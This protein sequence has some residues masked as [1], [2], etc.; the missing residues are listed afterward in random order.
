MTDAFVMQHPLLSQVNTKKGKRKA[1]T[2]A[3][4]R[5]Y[6]SSGDRSDAHYFPR[7]WCSRAATDWLTAM[8]STYRMYGR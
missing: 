3:L 1:M 4:T 6:T 5:T 2:N 8:Y 7:E